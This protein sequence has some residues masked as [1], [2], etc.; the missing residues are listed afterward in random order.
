MCGRYSLTHSAEAIAARFD[1]DALRGYQPRFN[2][3]PTDTM[4]VVRGGDKTDGQREL[5]ELRWGLVPFWADDLKIGSRMINARSETVANKPAF[6]AAFRRRRCLVPNDGF[7]EW[8]ELD[9]KKWP[10]RITVGD[11][12]IGAFAGLW[13]SWTDDDRVV[14]TYTI[15]T[16]AAASVVADLHNRMPVWAPE[17]HWDT[18]LND[19][20]HA[21]TTLTSMIEAFPGDDVA[22]WPVSRELNRPGPDDPALIEPIDDKRL[23]RRRL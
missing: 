3:A 2:V 9:G 16:T 18:W 15:L 1:V 17:E 14:E 12:Q 22:Y 11:D 5:S 23:P 8:V 21:E 10:I 4:P 20:E 13:E 19:D 7:Y 6:R